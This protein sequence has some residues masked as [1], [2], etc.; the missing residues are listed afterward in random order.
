MNILDGI[1]LLLLFL[2]A[3]KGYAQGL[4]QAL[5]GLVG[6]LA[7]ILLAFLWARPLAQWA[8]EQF[9]LVELLGARLTGLFSGEAVFAETEMGRVTAQKLP[10]ILD[11]LHVPAFLKIKVMAQASQLMSSGSASLVAITQ[12][13]ARQTALFLLQIVSFILLVLLVGWCIKLLMKLFRRFFGGTFI[14]SLNRI[15][16][17]LLGLGLAGIL[18][19]V[20]TGLA[21]P[22]FLGAGPEEVGSVGRM[23]KSSVLVPKFLDIFSDLSGFFLAR[24]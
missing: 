24:L 10:D 13:L 21:A 12:E 20:V 23:I 18:L 8:G 1:L 15:L 11:A 5:A 22:F 4:I 14:G 16:G 7:G 3:W 2:A 6:K 9:G 19:A 17:G